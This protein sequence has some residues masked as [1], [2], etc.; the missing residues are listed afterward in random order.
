MHQSGGPVWLFLEQIEPLH[1]I[2]HRCHGAETNTPESCRLPCNAISV[3]SVSSV[4]D[5]MIHN[6]L[7]FLRRTIMCYAMFDESEQQAGRRLNIDHS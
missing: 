1:G 6:V 2:R 5:L 3:L 4:V 7:R